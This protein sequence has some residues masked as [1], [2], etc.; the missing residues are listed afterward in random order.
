MRSKDLDPSKDGSRL[1]EVKVVLLFKT[2]D[3][4]QDLEPSSMCTVVL[5]QPK[6]INDKITA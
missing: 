4:D 2:S 1:M 3:R 5:D 6:R